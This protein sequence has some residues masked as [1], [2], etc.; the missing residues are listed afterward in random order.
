MSRRRKKR[1]DVWS[2]SWIKEGPGAQPAQ[3]ARKKTL[4]KHQAARLIFDR[5]SGTWVWTGSPDRR[6][7]EGYGDDAA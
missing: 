2:A 3:R 6:L 7:E 1:R 4:Q 5:A